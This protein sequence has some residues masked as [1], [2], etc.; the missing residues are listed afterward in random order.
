MPSSVMSAILHEHDITFT[1]T[2]SMIRTCKLSKSSSRYDPEKVVE[3]WEY[4]KFKINILQQHHIQGDIIKDKLR[5][6][7]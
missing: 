6:V 4:H 3:V 7:T 5:H 1:V 2:S